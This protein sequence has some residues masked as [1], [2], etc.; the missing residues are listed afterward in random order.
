MASWT[1]L[2]SASSAFRCRVSWTSRAFSSAT[3]RL[4]ESVVSRRSSESVNAC[5]RSRFWSE[6]TPVD[7]LR[8]EFARD[9]RLDA[10]DECQLRVPLPRLVDEAGVL[11]RHAE[12]PCQGLQKLLVGLR[13]GVLTVHVL[14]RDHPRRLGADYKRY[15]EPGLRQFPRQHLRVAVALRRGGRVFGDQQRLARLHHVF[16]VADQL[17]RLVGIANA[18]LDRVGEVDDPG[19]LVVDADVDHLRVED[20]TEPLTD[21]VVDR[22]QLELARE[23][24]LDAVDE[25]E[26]GVSLSRLLD[27]ARTGE[28]GADVLAD[29]GEELLVLLRVLD[30]LRVGLHDED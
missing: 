16:P 21:D 15:E 2:M 27:R 30:L 23:R 3:L 20:L 5:S 22:L 29:E 1:L 4:P 7:R 10:V 25:R 24:L 8:V 6:I 26:L 28:R 18:E 12:A 17:D 11:E 13:E 19:G 14:E 9:R